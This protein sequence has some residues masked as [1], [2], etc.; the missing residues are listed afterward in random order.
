M[1][2][3]NERY[4]EPRQ[5]VEKNPGDYYK[6]KEEAARHWRALLVVARMLEAPAE[7]IKYLESRLEMAEYVGD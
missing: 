3:F 2:D 7:D 1:N 6:N 4:P 5:V